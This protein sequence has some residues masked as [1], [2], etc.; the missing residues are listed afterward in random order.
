MIRMD[1]LKPSER[2]YQGPARGKFLLGAA[3]GAAVMIV[4]LVAA[5]HFVSLGYART[6]HGR[7]LSIWEGLEPRK[8]QLVKVQNVAAEMGELLDE[9]NEW[10]NSRLEWNR[11][12]NK[13]QMVIPEAVQLVRM[14]IRDHLEEPAN[15]EAPRRF[16]RMTLS[17]VI[18][19]AKAEEQ[20]GALI[21]SLR[22]I[23]MD[24]QAI[25]KSLELRSW[26]EDGR[27]DQAHSFMIHAIGEERLL[28]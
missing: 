12:L 27:G 10:A 13:V 16:F 15:A 20:V 1:L 19:G 2:R 4:I 5:Y 23:N 6:D 26:Q 28:E 25:F 3:A 17:G 7:T 8:K 11:I 9:L 14:E 22:D 18:F 24:D 21:A